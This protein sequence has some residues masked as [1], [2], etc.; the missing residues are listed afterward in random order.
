MAAAET[1]KVFISYAHQDGRET[2]QRLERDLRE[3]GCEVWLDRSR[4]AGGST[5][6]KEIENGLDNA[7]IVL[8][9]LTPGSYVSE[10][11]RAEQLRAL[12]KGKCVIPLLADKRSEVV[13]LYL[14]QTQYLDF[15][16][17]AVYSDQLEQLLEAMRVRSGVVLKE[18]Y[19]QTYT[20][21]P[22]LPI[23]Y[24]ARPK[25]L[26]HLRN[27]LLADGTDRQI[28]LTA[29]HGMGGIG[30]T[31]LAQ[32]ICRDEV[33]QQAFP[34]GVIWINVGREQTY[35]VVGKMREAA[36]VIEDDLRAYDTEE[37]ATNRYQSVLRD[38]AVLIVLDDVWNTQDVERFRVKSPRSRLLF[39]T[40]D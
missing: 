16:C 30:K 9:M 21:V 33:V 34:D 6:S 31:V 36:K 35:D 2:A 27:T 5:W 28:A 13:P 14:E 38:K 19:R 40:R 39:T 8:A 1:T 7:E 17:A 3:R 18:N 32:A 25:A 4:L 20:T 37:G 23:N 26:E 12:R 22:L 10:I 29:V 11:C 24:V 15:S